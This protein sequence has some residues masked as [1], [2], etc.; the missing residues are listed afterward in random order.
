MRP[1]A[2]AVVILQHPTGNGDPLPLAMALR[3]LRRLTEPALRVYRD[4][5]AYTKPGEARR[6]KTR[7]A[8]RRELRSALRARH[9]T[10]E[11]NMADKN[12]SKAKTHTAAPESAKTVF[13][14]PAKNDN[15]K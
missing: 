7:R 11:I 12:E 14:A 10:K 13:H 9:Y 1:L 6:L 2:N 5:C 15:A 4:H 3:R 8:R